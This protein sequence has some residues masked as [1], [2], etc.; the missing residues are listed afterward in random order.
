MNGER[1]EPWRR[2]FDDLKDAYVLGALTDDERREFEGYLAAHPEL[3]AEV[4]D[5]ASVANL[6]ALTPQQHEPPPELRGRL[7]SII[8][9]SAGANLPERPSRLTKLR[10]LFG[11]G[12]RTATVAAAAA[13]VAV[14]GLLVWNLSLQGE[15]EDLR[16]EL[17]SRQTYELQ[18]S[19]VAQDVQGQV[20]RLG[21]GRAVLMAENLPQAPEGK[22]YETWL[23]RD[24]VPEPAGL[25]EPRDGGVAATPIEGS[26]ESAD[27]VAVTVEPAGGSSA[28]TDDPLLSAKL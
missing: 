3:R 4:D 5:L 15:N 1:R 22:V 18:G 12:G 19:G 9:S 6:L 25:F 23:L 10:W 28:P 2:R 20:V 11:A 21:D 27:T 26:L 17:E 13:V 8:E 14:V 16:G 7:M 24:G